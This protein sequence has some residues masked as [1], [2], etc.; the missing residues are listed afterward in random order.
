[1]K[2]L[3][4]FSSKINISDYLTYLENE[5]NQLKIK[6]VKIPVNFQEDL[7][8]HEKINPKKDFAISLGGDGTV[9]HVARQ[10][11]EHEIIP[12]FPVNFG[13][14]GFITEIKKDELLHLIDKY[15]NGNVKFDERIL[16]RA[17]VFDEKTHLV[18]YSGLAL[19]DTI[20]ARHS[21]FKP[22]DLE[23]TVNNHYVCKYRGD[24]LIVATPTGSTAYSLSASGPIVE[25]ALDNLLITPIC[26][27][28]LRVRPLVLSGS[29]LIKVDIATDAMQKLVMDG[30][31][32]FTLK[33]GDCVSIN[34]TQNKIKIARPDQ[35]TFFNVLKE[36][37]NWLD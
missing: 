14:M 16:L 35:R 19:N 26:S 28:S 32:R 6:T 4:F 34:S 24:G 25:P 30:Q 33:M 36:K 20:I 10:L 27:H 12:I 13:S 15:L 23:L 22:I 11:F 29:S 8:L 2:A 37:L 5:L 3:I 31:E 9:L 17:K 18:K 1:M 7:D 21:S